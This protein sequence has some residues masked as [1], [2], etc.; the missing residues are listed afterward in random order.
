MYHFSNGELDGGNKRT[1]YKEVEKQKRWKEGSEKGW[2]NDHN[3]KGRQ[4]KTIKKDFL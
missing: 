3:C 4:R 2:Q 1:I